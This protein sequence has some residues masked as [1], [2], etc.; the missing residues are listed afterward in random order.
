MLEIKDR[1]KIARENAKIKQSELAEKLSINTSTVSRW[2]NGHS[3][4]T[5]DTL[6][7][8][9]RVLNTSVAFLS[10]ET[11]KIAKQDISQ[12]YTQADETTINN[13]QPVIKDLDGFTFW[14]N[15]LDKA[16]NVIERGDT[17]EI[18]IITS[19]VKSAY[20]MLTNSRRAEHSV[21]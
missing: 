15:V 17:N 9:A 5:S 14:G 6:T 21:L 4:P 19:L 7:Q 1:I 20:D 18:S 12:T 16:K 11:D 13:S 8:I 2:E 10:G 3:V